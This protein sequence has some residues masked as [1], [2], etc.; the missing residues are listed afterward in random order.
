[1]LLYMRLFDRC[2]FLRD[3]KRCALAAVFFRQDG[4]P[5]ELS[6]RYVEEAFWDGRH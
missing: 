2:L 1:M 6:R 5:A 4:V 3:A